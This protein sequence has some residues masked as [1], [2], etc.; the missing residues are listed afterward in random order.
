MTIY[1]VRKLT[2]LSL[3]EIGELLNVG[4]TKVISAIQTVEAR[5]KNG[6][7]E[8]MATVRTIIEEIRRR[9]ENE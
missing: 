1:L 6:D 5:L 9:Y 3:T 2:L 4:K 8:T 7:Q